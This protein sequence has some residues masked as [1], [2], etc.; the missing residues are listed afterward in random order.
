MAFLI[1]DSA[2]VNTK[3]EIPEPL[4][5]RLQKHAVPFV[6]TPISVIERMADHFEVT[7]GA[8]TSPKAGTNGESE[9][10]DRKLNE[11]HPP[12]LMH[13]RCRGTFGTELFENWN[14]LV[15]LAH[16]QAFA[17]A[18]T[19]EELRLVTHA[20]IKNGSH[21]ESGYHF[22]PEIEISVQGVDANRAWAY[23]LRLAQY[24]GKPVRASIEWRNTPNA[25]FPGERGTL[26]WLP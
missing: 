14:D 18:K 26:E 15:R 16:I 24:L 2:A 12:D 23:A 3:I 19:F 20:Q 7:F 4:Y 17:R 22:L 1:L 6:D 25:S 11:L 5:K 21:T 9:K 13:T 8:R 10:S